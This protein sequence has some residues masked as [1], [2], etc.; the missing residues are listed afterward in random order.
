MIR[1]WALMEKGQVERGFADF[2]K[3]I[4][5]DPQARFYFLRGNAYHVHGQDNLAIAD[6]NQ[7]IRINPNDAD[8]FQWRGKAYNAMHQY[9][10]AIADFTRAIEIKPDYAEAYCERGASYH[11]KGQLDRAISDLDQALRIKPNFADALY[12]RGIGY[13]EKDNYERAVAD[14]DQAIRLDPN[15]AE[16]IKWRDRAKDALAQPKRN[17][18]ANQD[19]VRQFA[20]PNSAMLA[21][22]CKYKGDGSRGSVLLDLSRRLLVRAELEHVRANI[23]LTVTDSEYKWNTSDGYTYIVERNTQQVHVIIPGLQGMYFV[24][25]CSKKDRI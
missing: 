25:Y 17:T 5:T 19:V 12:L 15:N 23:P 1:G 9:D 6:Y 8:Y 20:S 4:G 10:R 13:T 16:A 2:N 7:A 14:F 18:E 24:W 11:Q 3:A 21:L 22:D